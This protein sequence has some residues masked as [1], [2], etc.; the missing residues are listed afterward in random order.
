MV[1]LQTC[2]IQV[3]FYRTSLH[4]KW[5]LMIVRDLLLG[6]K[7]FSGYLRNNP[8]LSAKVLSQRLKEMEAEGIISKTVFNTTPVTVEYDLT[9][10]GLALNK[11]LYELSMYGAKYYT[12]EVFGEAGV[13]TEKA[14]NLFGGGFKLP[15]DEMEFHK[16]PTVMKANVIDVPS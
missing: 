10:K 8:D 1:E 5:T 7:H 6:V 2:P 14:V 11:I 13:E 9:S 3:A 16:S 15:D 4:K 12:E